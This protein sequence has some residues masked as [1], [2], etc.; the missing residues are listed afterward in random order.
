ML[1][2]AA[3]LSLSATLALRAIGLA[4]DVYWSDSS[5]GVLRTGK[6][7][8]TGASDVSTGAQEP[9]G[10]ALDP[11]AKSSTGRKRRLE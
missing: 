3:A 1:A 11:A 7:N 5:S 8:G 10:I 6:L 2:L 9:Q 4:D